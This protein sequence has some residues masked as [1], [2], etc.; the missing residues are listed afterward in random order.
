MHLG[1]ILVDRFHG[2]GHGQTAADAFAKQFSQKKLPD[3]IP[4]YVV[5]EQPATL[6]DLVVA[7]E[8]ASSKSEAR[9]LISQ[10]AV[11]RIRGEDNIRCEDP[12][13]LPELQSGDILKVGKR[14]YRRI[15]L[16]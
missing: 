3:D 5:E 9:R 15:V 11:S 7:A 13:A 10:G 1:K 16:S 2:D 4:D 12:N 14:R 8:C 6:I